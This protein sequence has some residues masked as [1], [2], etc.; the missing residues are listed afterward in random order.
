MVPQRSGEGAGQPWDL[1]NNN[2]FGRLTQGKWK[3]LGGVGWCWTGFVLVS[4]YWKWCYW[5]GMPVALAWARTAVVKHE[6]TLTEQDLSFTSSGKYMAHLGPH[7]EAWGQ[8][9]ETEMESEPGAL[10][11]L[12]SKG[13]VAGFHEFTL[14]WRVYNIKAE[15]EKQGASGGQGSRSPRAF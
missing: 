11:L 7:R 5:L 9:W 1:G 15:R 2:A 8:G 6:G 14:Y 12:G 13:R 3:D 4:A 10:A